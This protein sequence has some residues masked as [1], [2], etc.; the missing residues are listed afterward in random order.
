MAFLFRPVTPIFLTDPGM[1]C[2]TRYSESPFMQEP[3]LT[4]KMKYLSKATD[5]LSFYRIHTMVPL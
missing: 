5:K 1:N 4:E 2:T 3:F